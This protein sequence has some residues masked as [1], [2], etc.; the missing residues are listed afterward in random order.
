LFVGVLPWIFSEMPENSINMSHF[1]M[2]FPIFCML[3]VPP[4][5][6]VLCFACDPASPIRLR[7]APNG[8]L[9]KQIRKWRIRAGKNPTVNQKSGEIHGNPLRQSNM[10]SV[11]FYIMKVSSWENQVYNDGFHSKQCLMT[12]DY[13]PMDFWSWLKH[14]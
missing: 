1:W 14:T 13:S 12:R 9:A 2:L 5:T 7:S 3:A 11:F 10:A 8:G 4:K 6:A